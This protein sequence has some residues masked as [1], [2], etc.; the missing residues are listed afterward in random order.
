MKV[1]S[2]WAITLFMYQKTSKGRGQRGNRELNLYPQLTRSHPSSGFTTGELSA[3]VDIRG[4][5]RNT[6]SHFI[7]LAHSLTGDGTI[8]PRFGYQLCIFLILSL[9]I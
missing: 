6:S 7:P 3:L 8:G 9:R 1:M 4:P 2:S 5:W